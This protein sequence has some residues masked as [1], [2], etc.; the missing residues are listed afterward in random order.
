MLSLRRLYL[1]V[2]HVKYT[3]IMTQIQKKIYNDDFFIYNTTIDIFGLC[4]NFLTF[5]F[6][7][8]VKQV[9]IEIILLLLKRGH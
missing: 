3:Y 6:H 5:E 8:L 4:V 2:E 9:N 1:S 7:V